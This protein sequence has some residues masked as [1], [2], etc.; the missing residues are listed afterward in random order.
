MNGRRSISPG[1]WI[2]GVIVLLVFLVYR[3]TL[4]YPFLMDDFTAILSHPGI[5]GGQGIGMGSRGLTEWTFRLNAVLLGSDPASFR[6][7]N[8]CIHLINT[9]LVF[10]ILRMVF[11]RKA[12]GIGGG[13]EGLLAAGWIALA[14]GLHPLH[15]G[16]VI[17]ICQRFESLMGLFF[18]LAVCSYLHGL[19]GTRSR[20]FFDLSLVA[21]LLGMATKEVMAVAPFVIVMLDW[22]IGE[23]LSGRPFRSRIRMHVAW[24]L[25]I[26]A[27]LCL[28]F[29]AWGNAL[30]RGG[31]ASPVHTVWEYARTQFGVIA[32]YIRLSVL[33]Y[34]QVFD[35]VW[36]V[37]NRWWMILLQGSGVGLL[38]A[39]SAYGVVKRLPVA[40]LGVWFFGI[41]APTSSVLVV[42]DPAFEHRLYLPLAAVLVG[43]WCLGG[44]LHRR[45]VARAG[46]MVLAG[47]AVAYLVLLGGLTV[48]RGMDYESAIRLWGDTVDKRPE[49]GRAR[50]NLALAYYQTG[51]YQ[52]AL[53]QAWTI[54]GS[55]APNEHF[56]TYVHARAHEL[57]GNAWLAQDHALMA[58]QHY[59]LSLAMRPVPDVR[60]SLATA[61]VQSEQYDK[62]RREIRVVLR[63]DPSLAAGWAL[64]GYLAMM[65]GDFQPAYRWYRRSI[66]LDGQFLPAQADLAMFLASVPDDSLL[67][68]DRAL[69]L[70][71]RLNRMLQEPS[72]RLLDIQGMA[73]ASK[74]D[75]EQAIQFAERALA[76]RATRGMDPDPEL[77]VRLDRYREGIPYRFKRT[78]GN[79][80][81]SFSVPGISATVPYRP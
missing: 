42:Q 79:P 76:L 74:G 36:P 60:L 13:Q 21:G 23:R 4:A 69:A 81:M 26:A 75:F 46:R 40:L 41:L 5:M 65:D 54:L 56:S 51:D 63:E 24:G 22:V 7:V 35:Y 31:Y 9:L 71:D 12:V 43:L 16:C 27:G 70:C 29:S 39:I 14:W 58:V 18:L 2:A 3:D 11:R 8:V 30:D 47:T 17:Y 10:D 15:T 1:V 64:N 72:V 67:D 32:H 62:A 66:R 37:E 45:V 68:P 61:L 77:N 28:W 53:F 49:N 48:R 6:L 52:Q 33:P 34:P 25:L 19:S 55:G 73:W 78:R 80:G 59:R 50:I 44:R 57:A 38:V 20:L